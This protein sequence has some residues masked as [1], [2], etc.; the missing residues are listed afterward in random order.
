MCV[1]DPLVLLG[2][3]VEEGPWWSPLVGPWALD[4]CIK[5]DPGQQG[6]DRSLIQQNPLSASSV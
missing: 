1:S 3:R 2:K 5:Q 4:N 6:G